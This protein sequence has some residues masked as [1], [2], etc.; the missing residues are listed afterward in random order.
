M[1]ELNK[2]LLLGLFFLFLHWTNASACQGKVGKSVGDCAP[3][4]S[5]KS[6]DGKTYDLEKLRGKV[7]LVN[8]WATW[9]KPCVVEMP[10][11]QKAY[12]KLG[13]QNFEMLA[14]SID[15]DEK[16]INKFLDK[17]IQE[18]LKFPILFDEGKK[19]SSSFGT[20]QVPET[21]V[22]DKTGKIVDKTIGMRD[23]DESITINYLKLL[24]KQ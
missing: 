18:R 14:I 21:Y 10:S 13:S 23:W 5:L 7:V 11:M 8:F 19:V 20:F 15:N 17:D 1:K 3:N 4:F 9:C 24:L 22:I 6:I 16:L 12:A 2:V